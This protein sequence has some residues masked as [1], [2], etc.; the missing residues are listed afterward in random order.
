[1]A[2][3]RGIDTGEGA[4]SLYHREFGGDIVCEIGGGYFGCR[5]EDVRFRLSVSLNKRSRH[6]SK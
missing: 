3:R 5:R 6:R 1:M 4:I 2:P